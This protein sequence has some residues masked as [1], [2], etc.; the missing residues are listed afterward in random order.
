M[1]KQYLLLILSFAI[2]AITFGQIEPRSIESIG[3]NDISIIELPGNGDIWAGSSSQGIAF[4]NSTGANWTY[5]N[6]SNTPQLASDNIR[7]IAVMAIGTAQ[8]AVIGTS[9]GAVDFV[10]AIPA[11]L[12]SLPETSVRGV[13]YRPDSL[14]V[15]TDNNITRYDSTIA[16]RTTAASP[17]PNITCTQKTNSA[18]GGVWV[19]TANNGCFYTT[20]GVNYTYIDTTPANQKLVDN[21]VNA[22]AVDNNCVAKFIGTKGGFSVC[23]VANPCQNFTTANG[24][25]QND[26]TSIATGCGK[27]WLATRDSGVVVFT[28]PS[29]FTRVTMANGLPDNNITAIAVNPANCMAYIGTADGNITLVDTA[30][31][32]L[33]VL[34]GIE[35]V[36]RH[37]FVVSVYPQP[38]AGQLNFIFENEI[39]IG[40]LHITDI[41][42]RMVT[43]AQLRNAARA[44]ADVSALPSGL[45]FYQLYSSNQLIKTG[46]AEV[47]K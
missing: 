33:N 31:N 12:S 1:N 28:P 27:I 39:A 2:N 4:Y 44:T 11:S 22:I 40:E 9:N 41:S 25:P 32:V 8:H 23:P 7:A 10:D 3:L 30:R 34:S 45:Y 18:C 6:T 29:T 46:K 5:Y 16:F 19:G 43:V 26:I 17:L 13:V 21:R 14:W 15:L 36:N 24:L 37:S 20:N 47:I 35:K 38:A 42:G